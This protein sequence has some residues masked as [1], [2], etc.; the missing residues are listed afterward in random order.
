MT[1][2]V[3]LTRAQQTTQIVC[4]FTVSGGDYDCNVLFSVVP[5]D[6]NA[7]I[8]VTG[9]HQ[10]GR[11][12][13]QVTRVF[14]NNSFHPFIVRAFFTTFP[15][16][17]TY[18]YAQSTS[19]FRIQPNAFLNTP[20]LRTVSIT[21]TPLTNINNHAFQGASNLE[22]LNLDSNQLTT[23]PQFAFSGLAGL[24][25]INLSGNNINLISDSSLRQQTLLQNFLINFNSLTRIPGN[26]LLTNSQL[27]V[28]E[29]N[30]NN[31]TEIGRRFLDPVP[32]LSVL[33]LSNNVCVNQ[34]W[35][36]IGVG[37][38]PTKDDIR[39]HLNT[40]FMNYGGPTEMKEFYMELRGILRLFDID[41]NYIGSI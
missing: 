17:H 30:Q 14:I 11:D 15:N 19:P 27:F 10:I 35:N 1:L 36:G 41:G 23:I 37:G 20:G 6:E 29:A 34:N 4:S 18:G 25:N 33:G 39:G 40:C 5:D 16:L 22:T 24:L 9:Q 21:G 12:D 7:L 13:N 2:L 3:S 32:N 38:G 28:F 31:V 8:Q 26:L